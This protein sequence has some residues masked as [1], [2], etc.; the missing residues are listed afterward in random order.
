MPRIAGFQPVI[1]NPNKLEA[2]FCL[3]S[4]DRPKSYSYSYSVKFRA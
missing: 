1:I 2:I 3:K 4:F